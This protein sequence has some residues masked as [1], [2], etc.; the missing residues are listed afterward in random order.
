MTE[1]ETIDALESRLNK[2]GTIVTCLAAMM[3]M[4]HS[5]AAASLAVIGD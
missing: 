2:I 5:S 3:F 1:R 4:K